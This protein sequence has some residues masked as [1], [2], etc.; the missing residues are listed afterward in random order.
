MQGK[1]MVVVVWLCRVSFNIILPLQCFVWPF[2]PRCAEHFGQKN[3]ETWLPCVTAV[4]TKSLRNDS[5][6]GIKYLI[7]ALANVKPYS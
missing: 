2:S 3:I 7:S 6:A 4:P 1:I 5:C